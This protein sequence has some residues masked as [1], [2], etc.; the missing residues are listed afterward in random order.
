LSGTTDG[1]V[2]LVSRALGLFSGALVCLLIFAAMAGLVTSGNVQA[3]DEAVLRGL[4]SAADPAR[5]AG[6]AWLAPFAGDLTALAGTPVLTVATIVIAGWFI[7]RRETSMLVILLIAVIGQTL[8]ANGFKDLFGRPRPDIVPHL[9]HATGF[10]FPSGHS[11]SA[12]SIYL[13]LAA[14]VAS[15]TRSSAVRAYVFIV[16]VILALIVGASRVF[17]GVHYPTDVIGGLGFGAAWAAI[18]WIA[19]RHYAGQAFPA[20]PSFEN[21]KP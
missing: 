10:S 11:A 18:V 7:V 2:P 9:A 15:Q 20:R 21:Q 19:A 5:P 14:M 16:A 17:L 12:A 13:T 6:P 8:L 3:F 1:K 4:R